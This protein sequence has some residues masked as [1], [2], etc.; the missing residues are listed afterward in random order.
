M[1]DKKTLKMVQI[2]I[3]TAVL[4]LMAFTPL[5]YLRLGPFPITL[6][7]IPVAV[8]AMLIG[9]EAGALLGLIF[10]LTSFAQCFGADPT[11]VILLDINPFYTFVVC[12]PTRMLMG[13]G[14]GAIFRA[15]RK[16]DRTRTVSYFAGGVLAA[17]LNTVFFMGALILCF[18]NTEY[19]QGLYQSQGGGSI[20]LFLTAM[21]GLNGVVEALACGAAGGLISK[22]VSKA[23]KMD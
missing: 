13:Y 11:G 15:L 4:L 14:A 5:G 9:P 21:V 20:L 16:V 18:W 7:V 2:A 19:V 23:L 17:V 1:K 3:L 8:G 22:G 6:L 12:V 10:G